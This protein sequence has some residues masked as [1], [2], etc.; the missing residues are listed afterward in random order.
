MHIPSNL[1]YTDSH[2]WVKEEGGDRVTAGITDHAQEMLGDI[3]YIEVPPVGTVLHSSEPCGVVESVKT[4]SDIHAPLSG[5]VEAI[6]TK[7][8]TTPECVNETP[9]DAWFFRLHTDDRTELGNLMDAEAYR[10]FLAES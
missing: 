8:S 6:N 2:L 1:R 3:V 10:K 4:A 9:Y 7:V 5:T